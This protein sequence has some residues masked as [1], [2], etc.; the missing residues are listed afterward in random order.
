MKKTNNAHV[1]EDVSFNEVLPTFNLESISSPHH[2]HLDIDPGENGT[3]VT[4][5]EKNTGIKFSLRFASRLEALT[6][7]DEFEAKLSA[8]KKSL[9]NKYV[10]AVKENP[11]TAI[12]ALAL[13]A[14]FGTILYKSRDIFK[15]EFLSGLYEK[16][17]FD[18]F[19]GF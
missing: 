18:K 4:L 5:E 12:T 10:T 2:W 3:L 14:T 8:P 15:K 11:K 19:R 1:F 16:T 7:R 6:F 9:I 13:I 17:T